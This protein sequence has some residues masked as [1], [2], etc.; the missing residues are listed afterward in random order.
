MT[1]YVLHRVGQSIYD[2]CLQVY[3]TLDLLIKF[4]NDNGVTDLDDIPQQVYYSYDKNLVKYE[5]NQ[6]I[7]TTLYVEDT[8][9]RVHDSEF[10]VEFE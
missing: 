1:G 10:G 3:S 6:N 2:L 4:C 8:D 7:Y 9:G 5:G